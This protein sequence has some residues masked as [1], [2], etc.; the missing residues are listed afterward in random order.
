VAVT[1]AG[2]RYEASVAIPPRAFLSPRDHQAHYYAGNLSLQSKFKDWPSR[3]HTALPPADLSRLSGQVGEGVVGAR[4]RW[5]VD[6]LSVLLKTAFGVNEHE[7]TPRRTKRWTAAAGNI[8]CTT[9]Y[10]V[11]RDA[12]LLPTGVYGY[13]ASS[14]SLA[15][16]SDTV[17][18]GD[19]GCDV[20]I[21]GDLTK[22]MTKYGTFGFR[23]TMLDAGCALA[24]L[25]EAGSHLGVEARPLVD[26]DDE[27]LLAC[28]AGSTTGEPVV[29]VA[30]LGATHEK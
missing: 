3:T 27:A 10:V 5:G 22:I 20:V 23:L 1:T 14:H 7:T 4:D 21:T 26:W 12:D 2:A 17:P 13:A 19:G 29:A 16:V 15:R 9:A 11:C 24:T 6:E 8:G 25:R 28:L 30:T 18:P